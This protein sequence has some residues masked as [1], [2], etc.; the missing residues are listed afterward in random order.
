[1]KVSDSDSEHRKV[2]KRQQC[3]KFVV[4]SNFE[5]YCNFCRKVVWVVAVAICCYFMVDQVSF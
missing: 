5:E 4:G 2:S 1:M 3:F